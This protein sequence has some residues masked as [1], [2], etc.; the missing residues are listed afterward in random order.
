MRIDGLRWT[1]AAVWMAIAGLAAGQG[2][3]DHSF[4]KSYP[5]PAACIACHGPG[6]ELGLPDMVTPMM[7]N[8]HWTW[9]H[10]NAPSGRV[11]GKRNVINNYCIALDSNEPRCTS[12]HI[13]VGWRNDSFDFTAA[14]NMDCLVCHDT[15]A[16]YV[17]TPTGAGAPATNVNLLYVAQHVGKSSR[18]TCGACHFYG[19]GADAVKHG[20]LDS[21]MANPTRE[22]DV[23]MGVDGANMTCADCHL[24]GMTNGHQFTG[25]RYTKSAADHRLCEECHGSAPHA[26]S[27]LATRLNQHTD[28]LACQSCHVPHYARGGKA[29]KMTWDWS[30]AGDRLTNGSQR[31][32]KDA[33]G[34]TIYDSMKGTFTWAS[35]V[36]PEYVWF[37]GETDFRLATD[38]IDPTQVVKMNELHGSLTDPASRIIPVKRFTG[39]QPYDAVNHTLAVPHLFTLN[40]GDTNAYW[41][42]YNWTN[43]VSAG[44]AAAGVPFSGSL[45][46]VNTE[47]LWVQNHMVAP[48]EHAVTCIECH[49]A[50]GCMDFA[51]LGYATSQVAHLTN[52]HEVFCQDYAGTETCLACHGANNGLGLP[53]RAHE[54]MATVHWTWLVTN[55]PPGRTLG[56]RTVI[57]N[58]CIALDSNEP[59]CTSCHV[60]IGW[61][62]DGFDFADPTK[63][64]C[65]V[66][67]DTTATY[68]KSPTGAGAPATNVN[69]VLVAQRVGKTSR[70]T[71]G[72]CHFYGGGADAVK[73]GDLDSTMANPTRATDVHMGVDGANMTCADCHLVGMSN[74]HTFAGSRYTQDHASQQLCEDCHTDDPHAGGSL[75]GRMLN[76]HTRRVA[77]QTC[78]VPTFARGGKATKM[79]WDWSTAGDRLPNGAQRIV[80]DAAGN[81]IYDSMKGTFTW[82]ADEK[83]VYRWFNGEFNY[84]VISDVIDPSQRVPIN[85]L[86]GS[87]N[88]PK[89]RIFPVKLF[90]GVQAYDA[91]HNTLAVPHLFALNAGD[92]NAY[93]KGYNWTNAVA[94]GM[95][96]A[97]APFSGV[98]G[99]VTTE[100]YWIQNHMVAPAEE[101]LTCADCHGPDG[102][103]DF[104]ALGYGATD[105]FELSTLMG[106]AAEG[107]TATPGLSFSCLGG[108]GLRYHLECTTN[109]LGPASQWQAVPDSTRTAILTG[110]EIRWTNTMP[111]ASIFYRV[112]RTDP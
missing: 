108:A 66:C 2:W 97:G 54:V 56:K 71:C 69:L 77:C 110:A 9:V 65:L 64:D 45:G 23:H 101:A 3:Q 10:T 74:A 102:R 59:R 7:Q 68:V 43:A 48:A 44:M 29:T 62:D 80:K 49:Q 88:D 31:I 12:C 61:R 73:H 8:T 17:K 36:T 106:F 93:W 63:V 83:P 28:R 53:D 70:Q 26:G 24:E 104:A 40:A 27:A 1:V 42:G 95:A 112:M 18:Q 13:G 85:T 30:T 96:A 5:G 14:T 41:K 16:T 76:M 98:L 109:L 99:W 37:N 6:N 92:T 81:T 57:N 107:G 111:D 84:R 94:A 55:Q 72:A 33:A 34:N 52:P 46:W 105:S 21:T 32:I 38:V 11:L 15:T 75:G 19:G 91:V 4:L 103:L 58:Y 86:G 47:M 90:T 89:A 51:A 60:G 100:M 79:T 50:G 20:D 67:H 22:V 35:N 25:S 82:A 39:I 78:H 87:L